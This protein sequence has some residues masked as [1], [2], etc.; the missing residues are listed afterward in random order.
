MIKVNV[1]FDA[2]KSVQTE[3]TN[4]TMNKMINFIL[5]D[6]VDQGVQTIKDER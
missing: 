4:S 3:I 1:R 6:S 2:N 5:K